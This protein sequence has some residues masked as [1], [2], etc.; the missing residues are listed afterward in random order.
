[1]QTHYL[2]LLSEQAPTCSHQHH[3]QLAVPDRSSDITYT[4]RGGTSWQEEVEQDGIELIHT[5][6]S[7]PPIS[8]L[9]QAPDES[10]SM[11]KEQF[12]ATHG[13]NPRMVTRLLKNTVEKIG[14]DYYRY[15]AKFKDKDAINT[16][17]NLLCLTS[18]PMLHTLS[19]ADAHGRKRW[20]KM[21]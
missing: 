6:R 10:K 2:G 19:V 16:T 9:D 12:G 21:A 13:G 17:C 7:P 15:I 4:I 18:P 3:L 5:C 11:Y 20:G 1:M 14:I 8:T